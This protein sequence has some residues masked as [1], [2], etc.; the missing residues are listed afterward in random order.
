M[1]PKHSKYF[2]PNTCMS[3]V[4]LH[5]WECMSKCS[6]ILVEREEL[7]HSETPT[8]ATGS[9]ATTLTTAVPMTVVPNQSPSQPQAFKIS[10]LWV[11]F[12]PPEQQPP[13][14]TSKSQ[15]THQQMQPTTTAPTTSTSYSPSADRSAE[16]EPT[17]SPAVRTS[18][19]VGSSPSPVMK[20]TPNQFQSVIAHSCTKFNPY[21]CSPCGETDRCHTRCRN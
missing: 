3:K 9:V 5:D 4:H 15:Q 18:S 21:N 7:L 16:S 2:H 10:V 20:A 11:H 19:P 13:H 1:L 12:H 8:G 14:L 6:P 17:Q